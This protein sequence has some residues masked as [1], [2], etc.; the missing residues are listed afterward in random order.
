[1]ALLLSSV[2]V[3]AVAAPA[4]AATNHVHAFAPY[5]KSVDVKDDKAPAGT[6]V[7]DEHSGFFKLYNHGKAVGHFDYNCVITHVDP[8]RQECRATAHFKGRGRIAA[9]GNL[10]ANATKSRVAITGGTGEFNG[11]SGNLVLS[12]KKHGVHL[13]FNM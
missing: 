4:L 11:A 6:S 13:R 10:S 12:F 5:Y 2:I 9:E 3:A 1:M 7:G 8:G